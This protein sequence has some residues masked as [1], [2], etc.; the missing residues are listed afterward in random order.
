MTQIL[1]KLIEKFL[2]R[3]GLELKRYKKNDQFEQMIT[4]KE[5]NSEK[6]NALI[7]YISGQFLKKNGKDIPVT[8]THYLETYLI[9]KAIADSGYCVD[10]IDYRS[11]RFF[12][13]KKYNLFV[14]VRTNFERITN[15]LG[16]E[17]IKIVHLDTSHW[18]HNNTS[19][20][21]RCLSLKKRRGA[22][23]K[24][25][26][27]VEPNWAI[28]KADCATMLGNEYTE[29]TYKYSGKP[30][31]RLSVPTCI[32]YT[33]NNKKSYVEKKRNYIWFGSS[34]L[35]HKGLDIVLEAF[36]QMPEYQLY[37]CGPIVEDE[38]FVHCYKE[39]LFNTPNIHLEGWV[40]VTSDKFN[41][42]INN[43]IGIVYPS[44]AEGQAG[45]VVTCMRAGLIPIVSKESGVDVYDFG[46]LLQECSIEEIKKSVSRI[47]GLK[48]GIIKEM[49][50]KAWKYANKTHSK[51]NYVS[52]FQKAIESITTKELDY[53]ESKI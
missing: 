21:Q 49:S 38:G 33:W 51:E 30:I 17:C 13:G 36:K 42:I 44:C 5:K 43:C 22:V 27:T 31:Y 8:H 19:G 1:K 7:S 46:M 52:N 20:Y 25:F 32:E 53:E 11:K 48:T 35:V 50:L 15:Y 45:S 24:S 28:E 9:A 41:E 18:L 10:V 16:D 26:K 47:S 14:G 40:D 34:G 29:R 37:V 12:P 3:I 6:G 4:F 23:I 2:R 39:M